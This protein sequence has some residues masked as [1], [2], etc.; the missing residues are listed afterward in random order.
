MFR[1][2]LKYNELKTNFNNQATSIQIFGIKSVII[3]IKFKLKIRINEF[4]LV[5]KFKKLVKR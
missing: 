1:H 3:Q 4:L 2:V 5:T